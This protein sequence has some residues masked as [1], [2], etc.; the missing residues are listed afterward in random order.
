MLLVDDIKQ[1]KSKRY[2]FVALKVIAAALLIVIN[3]NV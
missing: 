3:E 2:N 1:H